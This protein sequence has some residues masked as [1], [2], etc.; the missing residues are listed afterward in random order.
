M[1]AR[2]LEEASGRIRQMRRAMREAIVLALVMTVLAAGVAP[3]SR[4]L[5]GALA[6]AAVVEAIVL[7]VRY[8]RRRQLLEHL[9]V[10]PAAYEIAEVAAYGQKATRR[11]ERERMVEA[12]GRMLDD[13][14]SAPVLW[15][16]ERVAALEIE[17]RAVSD[18]LRTAGSTVQAP[19]VIACR[20]LVT[21]PV[22]SGLYNPDLPIEDVRT[23]LQ[24]ITR[25]LAGE[26]ESA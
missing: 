18:A 7:G 6:I 2:A 3:V 11:C 21:N 13:G 14:A 9:A 26:R 17:L 15:L 12:F 25:T 19:A 16:P 23:K 4:Q 1:H 24:L 10:V 8:M 5:G 20:Q 22:R